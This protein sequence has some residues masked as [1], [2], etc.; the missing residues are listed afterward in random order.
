MEK[1]IIKLMK[2]DA[3]VYKVHVYFNLH[4]ITNIFYRSSFV[5]SNNR[6]F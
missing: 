5:T 2:T 3:I 6:Q 1:P 4:V